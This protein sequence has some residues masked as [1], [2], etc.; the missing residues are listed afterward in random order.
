MQCSATRI[1]KIKFQV[2]YG[3]FLT[4]PNIQTQL[5]NVMEHCAQNTRK[6]IERSI[7][8]TIIG[9]RAYMI[10]SR[11]G[12]FFNFTLILAFVSQLNIE[13]WNVNLL[14]WV[15]PFLL[16]YPTSRIV[17]RVGSSHIRGHIAWPLYVLFN[18]LET[19][20]IGFGRN[21][22]LVLQSPNSD[23]IFQC[24]GNQKS[25]VWKKLFFVDIRLS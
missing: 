6:K 13:N 18:A 20:N 14:N 7:M 8:N 11:G 4:P 3:L 21:S 9:R 1:T 23:C 16:A 12:E 24:N 22:S 15:S 19:R 5:N 17:R 2:E 25:W 10:A